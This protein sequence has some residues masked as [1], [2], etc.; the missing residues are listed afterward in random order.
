MSGEFLIN[1]EVNSMRGTRDI[2]KN[3][4][5]L[6]LDKNEHI[7]EYLGLVVSDKG[8]VWGCTGRERKIVSVKSPVRI[9]N[10]KTGVPSSTMI[11][12][13][14]VWCAFNGKPDIGDMRSKTVIPIDG[15]E[16]NVELS[17][18]KIIST[19]DYP[20]T[21]AASR[22]RFNE[23]QCRM[24]INEYNAG[25]ISQRKLAKEYGTTL[26][27]IQKILWGGYQ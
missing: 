18:L 19:S 23:E 4:Q 11:A 21:G 20:E 16:K 24:I 17:N 13:K 2:H 14:V 6:Q 8:R 9:Y 26:P 27:T 7:T 10:A 22:R 25:G 5:N 3:T 12:G 1:D 15:N